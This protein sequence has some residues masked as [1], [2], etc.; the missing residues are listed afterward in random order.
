LRTRQLL[1][2]ADMGHGHARL[3]V[4]KCLPIFKEPVNLPGP[5]D[6]RNSNDSGR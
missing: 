3:T 4:R 1:M 5:A 6:C 2:Y